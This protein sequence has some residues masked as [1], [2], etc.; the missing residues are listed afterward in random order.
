MTQRVARKSGRTYA[1]GSTATFAV[2][3]R[4]CA[5]GCGRKLLIGGAEPLWFQSDAPGFVPR[6][7]H[8]SCRLA[9]G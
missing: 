4:V 9:R 6:S 5:A 7:W 2:Y 1:Q 8:S 3:P